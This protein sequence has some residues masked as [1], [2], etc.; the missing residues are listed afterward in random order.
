MTENVLNQTQVGI[1]ELSGV[2]VG[3]SSQEIYF[4]MPGVS[5]KTDL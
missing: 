1:D 5:M 4:V 2:V 3:V